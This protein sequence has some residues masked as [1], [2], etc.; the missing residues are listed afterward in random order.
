MRGGYRKR[1]VY[2]CPLDKRLMRGNAPYYSHLMAHLR[3]ND[4]TLRSRHTMDMSYEDYPPMLWELEQ[5][6]TS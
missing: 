4:F 6:A 3:R 5:S 1:V 2:T